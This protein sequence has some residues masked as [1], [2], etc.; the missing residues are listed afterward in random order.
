ML[1][2]F[3]VTRWIGAHVNV[4]AKR[5]KVGLKF[6]FLVVISRKMSVLNLNYDVPR[7]RNCVA[8]HQRSGRRES[9]PPLQLGKLPFYR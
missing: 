8:G 1:V 2:G 9:N 7:H 3:D 4:G 6:G 5:R